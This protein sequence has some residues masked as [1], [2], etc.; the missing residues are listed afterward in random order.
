M[1]VYLAGQETREGPEF[2]PLQGGEQSEDGAQ[3]SIANLIQSQGNIEKLSHSK[4]ERGGIKGESDLEQEEDDVEDEDDDEDDDEEEESHSSLKNRSRSAKLSKFI[5]YKEEDCDEDGDFGSR[6]SDEFLPVKK[7]TSPE[8]DEKHISSAFVCNE[9]DSSFKTRNGLDIHKKKHERDR[10]YECRDCAESFGRT[11]D[12][13]EHCVLNHGG[14]KC[15]HCDWRFQNRAPY[16]MHIRV[17]HKGLKYPCKL[18]GKNFTSKGGLNTHNNIHLGLKPHKC[19]ICGSTFADPG[20]MSRHKK[21]HSKETAIEAVC[22]VCNKGLARKDYL[23]QHMKLHLRAGQLGESPSK[24]KRFTLEEKMEAVALVKSKGLREA[25][26]ELSVAEETLRNW[27]KLVT[28]PLYCSK[29]GYTSYCDRKLAK[30]EEKCF[31]KKPRNSKSDKYLMK[32]FPCET[33]SVRLAT[34]ASLTKHMQVFHGDGAVNM[35]DDITQHARY[36]EKKAHACPNC[37]KSYNSK[38]HLGDHIKVCSGTASILTN[39]SDPAFKNEVCS[40][41]MQSSVL[42]AAQ[43][44]KVADSTVRGWLRAL[45]DP[46]PQECNICGKAS[47]SREALAKHVRK[48]HTDPEGRI[49][50]PT[51]PDGGQ[52]TSYTPVSSVVSGWAQ[53]ANCSFVCEYCSNAFQT[54]QG[55]DK[56]RWSH[57]SPEERQEE[58]DA[59]KAEGRKNVIS[60]QQATLKDMY[61]A[62]YGKLEEEDLPASSKGPSPSKD[63]GKQR[64][65]KKDPVILRRFKKLKAEVVGSTDDNSEEESKDEKMNIGD[66]CSEEEDNPEEDNPEENNPEENNPE[67]DNIEEENLEEDNLDEVPFSEEDS[68][69]EGNNDDYLDYLEQKM[70]MGEES[71]DEEDTVATKNETKDEANTIKD[72][73]IKDEVES[74]SDM[75][76]DD[77]VY[78]AKQ[79]KKSNTDKIA[80]Q[81]ISCEYCQTE[82][83]AGK[84]TRHIMKTHKEVMQFTCDLCDFQTNR[85]DNVRQHMKSKHQGMVFSCHLCGEPCKMRYDLKTHLKK[86]HNSDE[87]VNVSPTK[88]DG[89]IEHHLC[90]MCGKNF[91]LKG[92][93]HRHIKWVHMK[94]KEITCQYCPKKFA[95]KTQRDVHEMTHTGERPFQCDQCP[96]SFR[97]KGDINQHI[98]HEHNPDKPVDNRTWSCEECGKIYDRWESF[99]NHK[100]TMHRDPSLPP[101]QKDS[102]VFSCDQ[103]PQNCVTQ[104]ALNLH[105][106]NHNTDKSFSCH[107]CD[108]AFNMEIKLTRHIKRHTGQDRDQC[109]LCDKSYACKKSLNQH[110]AIVHE[111]RTAN[112]ICSM[113][114][115]TFTRYTGLIAHIRFVHE[116]QKPV[117][118]DTCDMAF[119]DNRDMEKHKSKCSGVKMPISSFEKLQQEKYEQNSEEILT[120][121]PSGHKPYAFH[122]KAQELHPKA[123]GFHPKAQGFHRYELDGPRKVSDKRPIDFI[124]RLPQPQDFRRQSKELNQKLEDFDYKPSQ[125]PS[126]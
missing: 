113:C 27:V 109:H 99:R 35:T 29:C 46:G 66:D 13:L 111:G 87:I 57:L 102:K 26:T 59:K 20:S 64:S 15:P 54:Q 85:R 123:Q 83:K 90:P 68:R 21:I 5:S 49:I 62:K 106:L 65:L 89:A 84:M 115:K 23:E 25:S 48:Y 105:I 112:H 6:S 72:E 119:K 11:E 58:E 41:A 93:M 40:F 86:V 76:E 7:E 22:P 60:G 56:H 24:L 94:M 98:K 75:E 1:H 117:P 52:D 120:P 16:Q 104:A 78:E 116:G 96:R 31:A 55:L 42:V 53:A 110:I 88:I 32:P 47:S 45:D 107:I 3:F 36:K 101:L 80:E 125:P 103:C 122:P 121:P 71:D 4:A 37:P 126:P 114:S 44:Y 118:C 92:E 12:L 77:E 73:D 19:N 51:K 61:E 18:C 95:R 38:Y 39:K 79:R 67:E 2:D 74:D 124:N 8:H 28:S 17:K 33:C 81:I 50:D 91:K 14:L 69:E 9:C 10:G 43:T 63:G 70:D 108:A 34:Q 30:H 97:A 100:N 82:M